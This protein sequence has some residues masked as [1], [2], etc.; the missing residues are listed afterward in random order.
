MVH[1]N[2]GLEDSCEKDKTDMDKK[3]AVLEMLVF[4]SDFDSDSIVVVCLWHAK[5][6][7]R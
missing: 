3:S 7:E 1:S 4:A 5:F 2:I 6:T